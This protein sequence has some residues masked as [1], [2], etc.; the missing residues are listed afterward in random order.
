ML[1]DNVAFVMSIS[2]HDLKPC[3]YHF[4]INEITH[5][6]EGDIY[7]ILRSFCGSQ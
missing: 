3:R 5:E 7:F 6:T 1:L 2:R 4:W